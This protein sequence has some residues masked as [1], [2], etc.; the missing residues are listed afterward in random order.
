MIIKTN[1][2]HYKWGENC[3]AWNL[4][5]N[6]NLSVKLEKM[7]PGTKEKLHFHKKAQQFFFVLKGE[8]V[9][10][11]DG[12]KEI[13]SEKEGILINPGAQHFVANE[14]EK[15]LEFLVVSQPSTNS[16]RIDI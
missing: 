10:Y 5:A 1:S 15:E 6:E 11:I 12:K 3:D 13:I 14:T 8:A 7:P 4:V 9:F 16:D 2:N